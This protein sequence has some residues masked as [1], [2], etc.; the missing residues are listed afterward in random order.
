MTIK[1]LSY[2]G[3]KNPGRPTGKWINSLLP[4]DE[5]AYVE[6]FAGMLGILLSR[7]AAPTEI[8]ND[9]NRDIMNWWRV[10]RD[11]PGELFRLIHFTPYS[12]AEFKRC[13]ALIHNGG[14]TSLERALATYV[15]ISQSFAHCLYA[16][17]WAVRVPGP[18]RPLTEESIYA[19]ADRLRDVQLHDMDAVKLMRKF[20]NNSEV[21]MYC[22][23]PY[24]T[25]HIKGYGDIGIDWNAM[26]DILK[27]YKGKVAI[28]GY[29]DEWD[30]LG[31][32]RNE[33]PTF[34]AMTSRRKGDK[35]NSRV[36]VL[37]T[38]Y[39]PVEKASQA[40]FDEGQRKI[41]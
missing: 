24:R 35:K 37:W 19:L 34:T 33:L 28:S 26:Q 11:Q 10:L 5:Q 4:A 15:V 18:R 25:A 40:L 3:G 38:N 8:V 21:V 27:Q 39:Q 31:W 41:A 30:S 12:K 17:N 32:V 23:P 16:T 36:E 7:P 14:G 20:V 6:P 13:Q 1:T 9:Y 2:Y 29:N 22:D